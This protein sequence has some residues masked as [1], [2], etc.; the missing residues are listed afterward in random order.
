MNTAIDRKEHGLLQDKAAVVA[1]IGLLA[2]MILSGAAYMGVLPGIIGNGDISAVIDNVITLEQQFR[3]AIC[4]LTLN[5][6]A[7][8]VV[9][10][11]L[12]YFLRPTGKSISLLALLFGVIHA[13]VALSAVNNL[14][15]ILLMINSTASESLIHSDMF[16]VQ[17]ATLTGAFHWAWQAGMVMFGVHMLLR[18]YLFVKAGYM[19]KWLGIILLIVA[20]GYLFDGF[21]QILVSGFG[22]P[23]VTN[24]VGWFEALLVIWLLIKGRKTGREDI[25]PA[26]S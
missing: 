25:P 4:L 8:I 19:K 9:F 10:W 6:V 11:A 23:L 13:V 17:I 26:Y 2:N 14:I 18:G 16:H 15:D 7:D 20:A 12:Y 24:Y 1:A 21:G 22:N 5:V 3:V